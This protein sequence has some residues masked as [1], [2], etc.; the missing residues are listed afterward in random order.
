M[1][2]GLKVSN[3]AL[4]SQVDYVA[5]MTNTDMEVSNDETGL[6]GSEKYYD[7]RSLDREDGRQRGGERRKS[8]PSSTGEITGE[9][10]NK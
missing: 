8:P 2:G 1:V 3:T 5:M 9:D 4:A 10:Y 6:T 7:A